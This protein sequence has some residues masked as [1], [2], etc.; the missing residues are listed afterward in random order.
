MVVR[1]LSGCTKS[2]NLSA[3][4]VTDGLVRQYAATKW[5][6]GANVK[7]SIRKTA[8]AAYGCPV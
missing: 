4:D 8:F 3:A 1:A 2:S 5:A 6:T 7:D